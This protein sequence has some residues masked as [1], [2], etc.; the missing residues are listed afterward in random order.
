MLYIKPVQE[1]TFSLHDFRIWLPNALTLGRFALVPFILLGSAFYVF[2]SKPVLMAFGALLAFLAFTCAAL[3]DLF[4]GYLARR[5]KTVSTFGS[6]MDPMAG[7]FFALFLA[8][9][10]SLIWAF[11]PAASLMI[12][13]DIMVGRR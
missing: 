8:F 2:A 3:F 6:V 7:G 9:P 13:R 10:P 4:D 12:L 11:Y 1:K 5:W